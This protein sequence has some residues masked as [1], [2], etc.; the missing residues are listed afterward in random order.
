M[1]FTF[2]SQTRLGAVKQGLI[3]YQGGTPCQCCGDFR[4]FR[5][6]SNYLCW[7]CFMGED[8]LTK[9]KVS[10]ATIKKSLEFLET[11]EKKAA[12]VLVA[13]GSFPKQGKVSSRIGCS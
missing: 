12:A 4:R 6:E 2:P 7:T 1:T 5:L 10:C 8:Y 13:M 3:T 11:R 9:P